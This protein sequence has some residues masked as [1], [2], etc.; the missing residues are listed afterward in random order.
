MNTYLAIFRVR[1]IQHY[2]AKN[3]GAIESKYFACRGR[4][5][6]FIGVGGREGEAGEERERVFFFAVV[7]MARHGCAHTSTSLLL[8]KAEVAGRGRISIIQID[9]NE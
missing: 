5:F 2:E 7:Y 1:V 4:E 8:L 3:S 6:R 9:F